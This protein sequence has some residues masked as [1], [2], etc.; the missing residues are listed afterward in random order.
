MKRRQRELTHTW[1]SREEALARMLKTP[2]ALG[3][4]DILLLK[5][6][7]ASELCYVGN[8]ILL[9]SGEFSGLSSEE[10]KRKIN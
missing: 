8:G 2:E 9:H 4:G 10:A 6:Y 5:K 1:V 3:G 7:L